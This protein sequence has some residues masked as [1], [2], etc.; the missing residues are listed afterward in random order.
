[1]NKKLEIFKSLMRSRAVTVLGIG[2]SN[3]PLIDFLLSIGAMVTA[4]DKKTEAELGEE[5]RKLRDLGV[6][7]ICGEKYLDNLTGDYIFKTPGMRFDIPELEAARSSGSIVTSEMEVFFDLCPAP[8]IAVTG[9][10]GKTTTTTLIC[11]ILTAAGY[12]CRLGGNIGN[13]LLPQIEGI[14]PSELIVLELSSFQ[15]H[16]L[17]KSPHIAVVT[18]ISP[19]HLDMH[20][21]YKEY[22]AA[23]KNIILHQTESDT[24]VL[25]CDNAPTHAFAADTCGKALF[26]GHDN[27]SDAFYD[28]ES[29]YLHG[30]KILDRKDI[31][32]CGDHNAENLMAA[33]LATESYVSIDCV[34]SVARTFRGVEHRAEFVREK[35]GVR[36]YNSSIDSSPNRTRSTLSL[37]EQKVILISGGKDKGIP[38][39]DLGEALAEKVKTL[40]LIGKTAP[41]IHNALKNTSHANEIDVYYCDTYEQVVS[42]ANEIATAGDIVLLSP[43]STSFDMFKNFEERGRLFKELVNAL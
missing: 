16:T 22:I 30:K 7:L 35:D 26:F 20:K 17:K 19:N 37:F 1:M 43:A 29:I 36:Y 8:I 34:R 28:R 31:P 10:D 6:N 2:I 5:A 15:L 9:S 42:K 40:I 23:K 39:D 12:K 38:Y 4:R 3:A 32:L 27:T 14:E 21:S 13:P 18:N 11:K 41:L 24:A 25:N 33:M